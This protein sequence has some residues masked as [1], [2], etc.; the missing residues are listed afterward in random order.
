M[1]ISRH[2]C[3]LG[4]GVGVGMAETANLAGPEILEPQLG[5]GSRWVS[6]AV[7]KWPNSNLAIDKIVVWT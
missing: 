7:P 3:H 1:A 4:T 5:S 2:F 6:S